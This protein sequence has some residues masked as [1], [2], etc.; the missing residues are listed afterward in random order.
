[1]SEAANRDKLLDGFR[2]LAALCVVFS[3]G[4]T[5]RYADVA[6]L[7]LLR[8]LAEPIAELG[9]QVFFVLS[10]FIITS[11]LLRE[12]QKTGRVSIPAFYARRTF[13]I[14]PPFLVMILLSGATT[15]DKIRA[16]TFTCNIVECGWPIAHSWSLAVE[17]QF[18]L[19]WPLLFIALAGERRS[20]LVAGL[21]ALLLTYAVQPLAYHANT[22]S[23][24]CIAMGALLAV[25]PQWQ[26]KGRWPVWSAVAFALVIVPITPA[27]KV[28]AV[29]AP[30][31]IAYLVFGARNLTLPRLF[32]ECAPM[33]YVGMCSYSL[34]LWQQGFLGKDSDWPI[35]LLP[36]A[37]LASVYLVEKPFIKLGHMLSRRLSRQVSYAH[38]SFTCAQDR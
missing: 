18:Y 20:T 7:A 10:G 3:H 2:A 27:A 23:F 14:L 1:M 29:L 12:E 38:P 25:N 21:G 15:Y 9:V 26:P 13:R 5:Y 6:S 8:R 37:V 16:A 34:Y 22:L 11:L 19:V 28:G 4:V 35:L 32:L 30:F 17:E 31:L 33:Q 24:A 36:V